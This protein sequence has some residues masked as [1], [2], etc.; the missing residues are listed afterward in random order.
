M[1]IV[2]KKKPN[3]KISLCETFYCVNDN[4]D[5]DSSFQVM[6]YIFCHTSLVLISNPKT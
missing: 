4:K 2:L 1:C 6:C 3:N 5:V